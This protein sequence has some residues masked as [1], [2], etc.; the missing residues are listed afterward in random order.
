METYRKYFNLYSATFSDKKVIIKMKRKT[1][2]TDSPI[3]F[4]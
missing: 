2:R 3:I 1:Q 4:M